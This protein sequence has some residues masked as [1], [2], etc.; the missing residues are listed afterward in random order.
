[1]CATCNRPPFTNLHFD[2]ELNHPDVVT[3][4]FDAMT[5]AP[6]THGPVPRIIHYYQAVDLI[7]IVDFNLP[8]DANLIAFQ[9]RGEAQI[10]WRRLAAYGVGAIVYDG[11]NVDTGKPHVCIVSDDRLFAWFAATGNPITVT[12]IERFRTG[13]TIPVIP[14]DE[15]EAMAHGGQP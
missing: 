4:L 13:G 1:V 10:Q 11:V 15:W 8:P 7:V 3:S 14:A 5:T 9:R 6:S 12:N 2:Y